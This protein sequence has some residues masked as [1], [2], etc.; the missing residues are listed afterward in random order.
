MYAPGFNL[1]AHIE[2]NTINGAFRP[3]VYTS[4]NVAIPAGT[5]S[6]GANTGAGSSPPVGTSNIDWLAWLASSGSAKP[7]PSGTGSGG[8]SSTTSTT[9]PGANSG[10]VN[11]GTTANSS[12][13]AVALLSDVAKAD[14]FAQVG[15]AMYAPGFNLAAHIQ[16]NTINGAFRPPV[17]TP[18]NIATPAGTASG[19]TNTSAGATPPV[20]TTNV[21]WLGWL[22]TNEKV[23]DVAKERL[24][25]ANLLQLPKTDSEA[26][27]ALLKE[28]GG[29]AANPGFNYA[30]HVAA[31]TSQKVLK[32]LTEAE[33]LT[34]IAETGRAN[35][36]NFDLQAHNTA[37]QK[38]VQLAERVV[39]KLA[40]SG[41]SALGNAVVDETDLLIAE[42][43]LLG[44]NAD[45][46][47]DES[48]TAS[49]KS[50][51]NGG[52]GNDLIKTGQLD[53]VLIAG[54]GNDTL[55]GGAGID[56]AVLDVDLKNV[57]RRYDKTS[58]KWV[59]ESTTEGRDELVNVERINLNDKSIALDI[60]GNAG[61]VYR[62]Y[63]AVFNRDP[64]TGDTAGLGYW[65]EQADAGM[66]VVELSARF[67]D[68]NEFR[69]TY[70]TNSANDV[71]ISRVYENVLG[72]APDP[73]GKA[74]WLDQLK[75][76]PEKTRKKILAD[77]AE[78][79]ENKD[80]VVDLIASGIVYDPW[81]A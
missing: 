44:S 52:A 38:A 46:I 28:T 77:F 1:A 55:D 71:F 25:S 61:Q 39:G 9:T 6:G 32:G 42:K 36:E 11:N 31:I 12:S 33:V 63:K 73:A 50:I 24:D 18:P 37:K 74:W 48:D 45:D 49:E 47:L 30:A 35:F 14:L 54:S 76:N 13:Q 15:N 19:G 43:M 64:M 26:W 8:A 3:P 22:A 79:T 16:A 34:L 60:D 65:I 75:S 23:F 59:I 17:Y 10:G 57:Q 69:S 72:R 51:I 53:N 40:A 80:A 4:P 58:G 2:A 67:I 41:S 7:S 68:S 5:A 56:V 20:G 78:S 66:N 29:A 62:V 27:A 81:M 21:D 70:G